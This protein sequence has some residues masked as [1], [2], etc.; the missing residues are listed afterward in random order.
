M[1]RFD[2]VRLEQIRRHARERI[3]GGKLLGAA[4]AVADGN[5]VVYTCVEGFANRAGEPLGR[6]HVFRLASMTKPLVAAAVMIQSERGFLRITDPA[7]A[8][9]PEFGELRL[10]DG[11]KARPVEIRHLLSHCSG[12]AQEAFGE[13]EF[14]AH[15]PREGDTLETAVRRYAGMRLPFQPGERCGYSAIAG[16]D[17][18]A[19]I[20][21]VTSGRRFGEFLR[22][23]LLEPLGM[24]DTTFHPDGARKARLVELCTAGETGI[25]E[26]PS[27]G[28]FPGL[29]GG[30]YEC[31]GGGLVGTL[32][33]YMRFARML[34]GR[35]S[36]DGVRVLAPRTVEQMAS[37]AMPY[38]VPNSAPGMELEMSW[39]LGMRVLRHLNGYSAPLSVGTFGWSGAFGTHFFVDPVLKIAAVYMSNLSNAGGAGAAT[40][41]EFENDVIQAAEW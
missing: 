40:A 16:F 1:V 24:K 27:D 25:E 39:G 37:P 38:T 36:L 19:R 41:F 2:P 28:I 4:S 18:L 33:D 23:N 20:V 12:I 10:F 13:A 6:E 8:Y 7:A 21:E 34:L 26:Y 29:P 3:R 17:I 30:G 14:A 5:G 31:G 32:D 11:T 9:L 35:G 22:E 15:A